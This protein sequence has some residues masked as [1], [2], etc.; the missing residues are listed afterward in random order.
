MP[1]RRRRHLPLTGTS[2]PRPWRDD[3]DDG[4]DDDDAQRAD[5]DG[6]GPVVHDGPALPPTEGRP[7]VASLS[8]GRRCFWWRTSPRFMLHVISC[9]WL[10]GCCC[11][12]CG[13][14]DGGGSCFRCRCGGRGCCGVG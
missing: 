6:R 9:C 4:D 11:C 10:L 13:A 8:H 7:V 12:C 14:G 5:T 1:Y 2:C 3:G